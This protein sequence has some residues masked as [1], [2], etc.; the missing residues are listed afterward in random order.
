ME[1]FDRYLNFVVEETKS[2]FLIIK[3][4]V[5]PHREMEG[6]LQNW[7]YFLSIVIEEKLKSCNEE[8]VDMYTKIPLKTFS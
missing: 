7:K 6:I 8:H 1:I 3:N 4:I 5:N 2:D